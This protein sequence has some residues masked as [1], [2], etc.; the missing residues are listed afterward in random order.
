MVDYESDLSID[1]GLGVDNGEVLGESMMKC[2]S[3]EDSVSTSS[4]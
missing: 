1:L 2:Y 4:D 3:T